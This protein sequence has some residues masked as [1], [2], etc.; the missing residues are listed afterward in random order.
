MKYVSCRSHFNNV[1][2]DPVDNVAWF[3][4]AKP[5]YPELV[6]CH[7]YNCEGENVRDAYRASAE[8][9]REC[10]LD[11]PLTGYLWPGL[12]GNWLQSVEFHRAQHQADLSAVKFRDYVNAGP[13][14]NVMTHSLGAKIVLESIVKHGAKVKNLF[15]TTLP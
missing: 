5:T 1:D 10:G 7:G 14:A 6:L 2:G 11:I 3:G 8:M 13:P 4:E 15:L 12:G 9:S